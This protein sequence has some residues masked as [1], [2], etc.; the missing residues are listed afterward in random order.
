M[1]VC[2]SSWLKVK[3]IYINGLT[4]KELIGSFIIERLLGDI[5]NIESGD[6]Q[7]PGQL[8]TYGTN[9]TTKLRGG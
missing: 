6:S 9:P 8:C 5:N 7:S 4:D 3:I 2:D 1:L